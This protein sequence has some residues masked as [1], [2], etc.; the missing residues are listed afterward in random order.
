MSFSTNRRPIGPLIMISVGLVV[1]VGSLVLG[2]RPPGPSPTPTPLSGHSA[3]DTFPDIPRVSLADAKA[4]FESQTAVFVD[5][6][7]SD[8]YAASHISRALSIP[9]AD[10][11]NRAGELN[12]S[13]WIITYCT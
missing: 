6:R 13:D 10:L 11:E 8:S 3:E 7:D 4:A 9:L 1:L 12:R 5:V 2:L